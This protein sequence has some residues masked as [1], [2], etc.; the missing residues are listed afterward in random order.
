MSNPSS[1]NV[2][3]LVAMVF[4]APYK[5]PE[6]VDLV[7]FQAL[8]DRG[9]QPIL[10]GDVA[11]LYITEREKRSEPMTFRGLRHAVGNAHDQHASQHP[12]SFAIFSA[13]QTPIVHCT[14]RTSLRLGVPLLGFQPF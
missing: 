10:L 1:L 9:P 5:H 8:G 11:I 12:T 3:G 7:G 14:W 13:T 4:A 2:G 6:A